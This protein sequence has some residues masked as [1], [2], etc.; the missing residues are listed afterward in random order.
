[1]DWQ[2]TSVFARH[3]L[4]IPRMAWVVLVITMQGAASS[5]FDMKSMA[6]KNPASISFERVRV[7][8]LNSWVKAADFSYLSGMRTV[9]VRGALTKDQLKSKFPTDRTLIGPAIRQTATIYGKS[10]DNP[11]APFV[12]AAAGQILKP[13]LRGSSWQKF[14]AW[15]P[16]RLCQQMLNV[17]T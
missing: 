3:V 6:S 4:S 8:L 1:M 12:A 2:D 7:A 17:S 13:K 10:L 11:L 5:E 16:L 9:S 14:H 15:G